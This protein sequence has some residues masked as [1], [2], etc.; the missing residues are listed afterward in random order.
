VKFGAVRIAKPSPPR[1]V[2]EA[3]RQQPRRRA[4][5]GRAIAAGPEPVAGQRI[6]VR[7]LDRMGSR[8][9][10]LLPAVKQGSPE[11]AGK[12]DAEGWIG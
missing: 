3:P 10:L 8:S 7:V 1:A 4:V 6:E 11:Q 12:T 5:A 2:A 9:R